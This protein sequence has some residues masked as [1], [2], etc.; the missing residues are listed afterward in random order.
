MRRINVQ[1]ALLADLGM[2]QVGWLRIWHL[3]AAAGGTTGLITTALGLPLAMILLISAAAVAVVDFVLKQRWGA[4]VA[5]IEADLPG[6]VAQIA[7][8]LSSGISLRKALQD[9]T[10]LEAAEPAASRTPPTSTIIYFRLINQVVTQMGLRVALRQ[11]MMVADTITPNLQTALFLLMRADEIGGKEYAAA[12]LRAAEQMTA[13]RAAQTASRTA[14]D[15]SQKELFIVV[16]IFLVMLVMMG[17]LNPSMR[18]ELQGPLGTR[19]SIAVAATMATGYLVFQT[20]VRR[21]FST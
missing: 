11:A 20:A 1:Q 21:T 5:R 4:Y 17:Y 15:K 18:A 7:T 8:R 12:L 9:L 6:V 13:N 3:L 2:G 19:L 10:E 16:G 14:A